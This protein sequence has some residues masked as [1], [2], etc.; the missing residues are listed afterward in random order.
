MNL[1]ITRRTALLGALSIP[2]AARAMAQPIGDPAPANY[3]AGRM[4][5][6]R[7]KKL[8]VEISGP[9][10]APPLVF[11]HGGPGEGSWEFGY[12]QKERLSKHLR[13]IQFDQRGA[14]RSDTIADDEPF[15][16]DDLV[17]DMEALRIALAIP[18]WSFLCHSFGGLIG[19]RYALKYP[20]G[21]AKALFN[22]PS[23]DIGSSDRNQLIPIAQQ[24]EKLGMKDDAQKAM[25]GAQSQA[26]GRE[27]W[28]AFIHLGHNLPFD[29]RMDTFVHSLPTG[30][31]EKW[32]SDSNLPKELWFKGSGSSQEKLWNSPN[33]FENLQPR[34]AELH[35]P[36]LLLKGRY[37]FT[38]APDQLAAFQHDP[39]AKIVY[40][41]NSG[42][43]PEAEEPD[44]F[45]QAVTDFMLA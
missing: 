8:Y 33:I 17:E 41:E 18:R 2:V 7:G 42:H 43:L 16:L 6:V 20:D 1:A 30:Y 40:F 9:E 21:V 19:L 14:F 4:V 36:T 31:T 29:A 26:T 34:L 23:I 45:A 11:I 15:S 22:N 3:G 12:Y 25:A 27:A 35:K 10:T 13:L 28:L 32:M 5:A 44:K 38:T 39:Y 24:Y 37:D